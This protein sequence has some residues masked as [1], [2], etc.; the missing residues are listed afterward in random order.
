MKS[1]LLDRN[2]KPIILWSL[3]ED[4]IFFEGT[5]PENHF[6][7]VC[8]SENIVILDVDKKQGKNGFNYI[9][10]SIKS[11]LEKTFHY[12][13]GSGGAHYFCRY[14]G[15]KHLLNRATK[16]GLDLRVGKDNKTGNNGGYVRYQHNEDIRKCEHLILECSSELNKFLEK[17]FSNEN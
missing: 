15:N 5:V 10:I 6:L 1:F 12:N 13:T 8:P 17:L 3:L 7:A 9:P 14:T 4:G 11:E 16:F 2:K